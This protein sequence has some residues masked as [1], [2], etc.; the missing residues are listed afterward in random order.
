MKR[1]LQDRIDS[2]EQDRRVQKLMKMVEEAIGSSTNSVFLGDKLRQHLKDH[3]GEDMDFRDLP[4]AMQRL[5]FYKSTYRQQRA[6]RKTRGNGY[7]IRWG[8]A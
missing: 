2:A 7:L 5:G 1:D 4:E 8:E 3:L 6:W